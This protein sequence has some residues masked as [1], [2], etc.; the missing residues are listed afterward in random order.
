MAGLADARTGQM[1]KRKVNELRSCS[2]GLA[3]ICWLE[4]QKSLLVVRRWPVDDHTSRH[5]EYKK[6]VT[7]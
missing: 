4:L 3:V 6:V 2:C 5:H 7:S 1:A